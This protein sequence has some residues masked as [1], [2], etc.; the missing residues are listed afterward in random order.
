MNRKQTITLEQVN[1]MI[2]ICKDSFPEYSN[3][4]FT[5]R[6]GTHEVWFDSSPDKSPD[7]QEFHWFELCVTELPRIVLE[8]LQR[9]TIDDE[10]LK[11]H[12]L[13]NAYQSGGEMLFVALSE[14]K[15]VIDLLY[16]E[17]KK[18]KKWQSLISQK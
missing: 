5:T 13:H 2:E 18:L 15:H 7:P 3:I 10:D 6:Y 4:K 14:G 1:K 9:P 11:H 8:K 16:K 17:Y 12:E